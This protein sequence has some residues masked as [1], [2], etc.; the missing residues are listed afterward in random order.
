MP[1]KTSNSAKQLARHYIETMYTKDACANHMGI[2][3]DYI[4]IGIA[5]LSM[6]VE[7]GRLNGHKT[8]HGG[9]IFTLADTAFA[10]ACNSEGLAAVASAC[11][12]DFTRP[13][14][15]GDQLTAIASVQ[16]QGKTSGLYDVKVTN[17]NGKTVAFFRGH[18]HRS[19]HSVLA[20]P[21]KVLP[22]QASLP[23]AHRREKS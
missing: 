15:N 9:I 6:A 13:V 23:K 21:S 2:H 12:I 10:Y 16:H 5:Q 3:I 7:H 8:C 18:A 22:S 1:N 4:D 17:Q 11:S 20:E 14:F 19:G